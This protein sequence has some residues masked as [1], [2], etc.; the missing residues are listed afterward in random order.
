MVTAIPSV[1]EPVPSIPEPKAKRPVSEK[2]RMNYLAANKRRVQIL[3][4]A[5]VVRLAAAMLA[6]KY[7]FAAASPSPSVA[8]ARVEPEEKAYAAPLPPPSKYK[9]PVRSS[10]RY[11]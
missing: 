8:E 6:H 2:Q 5:K 3:S 10:I 9:V 1:Q 7:G 11:L 4:E